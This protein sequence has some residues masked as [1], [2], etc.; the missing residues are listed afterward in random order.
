MTKLLILLLLTSCGFYRPYSQTPETPTDNTNASPVER[1]A[2]PAVKLPTV[3]KTDKSSSLIQK[4]ELYLEL[5]KS[6]IAERNGLVDDDCDALMYNSLA[7]VG[8]VDIDIMSFRNDEGQWFRTP[9]MDCYSKRGKPASISRDMILGLMWW[10]WDTK[11]LKIAEDL[12]TY[13]RTH[14]W[15]M[16]EGDSRV[17]MS[18]IL[19]GTLA[20]M[21]EKLGGESFVEK[22]APE[23][24]SDD[25]YGYRLHL[26]LL[27]S[28]LRGEILGSVGN[29]TL[30]MYKHY[31]EKEPNNALVQF[32][33]HLYTDGIQNS[34]ID[35]LMKSEWWP[36]E[37][38]PSTN[39]VC[40]LWIMLHSETRVDALKPDSKGCIEYLHPETRAEIKT[41]DIDEETEVLRY[42]P[43][44]LPCDASDE[45]EEYSG[46][47]FLFL[48]KLIIDKI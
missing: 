27:H 6:F 23:I 4:R 42:D 21:I 40:H 14:Y 43:N 33:L 28:L 11:N 9:L 48:S 26:Q 45:Y 1:T 31:A 13:G 36:N 10:I 44:F 19:Q 41:C 3:T 15:K 5:I 20:L 35:I 17:Y 25:L 18:P 39:N 2:T 22:Y 16:G 37:K 24:W 38:L 12:H 47:D 8:G 32:G 7:S 34:T 46:G 29:N 30:N